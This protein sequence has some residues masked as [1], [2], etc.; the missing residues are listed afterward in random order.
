VEFLDDLGIRSIEQLSIGVVKN[1]L[2]KM[3][4]GNPVRGDIAA[5]FRDDRVCHICNMNRSAV[6]GD[7]KVFCIFRNVLFSQNAEKMQEFHF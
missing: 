1:V 7:F 4:V 3:A 5:G 2:E 6:N